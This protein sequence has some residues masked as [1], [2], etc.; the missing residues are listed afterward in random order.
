MADRLDLALSARARSFLLL[1]V[2]PA[3]G[4]NVRNTIAH[5]LWESLPLRHRTAVVL[6]AALIFLGAASAG[7][8]SKAEG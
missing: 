6:L 3:A 2:E 5:D 1:L 7:S 8:T 4:P